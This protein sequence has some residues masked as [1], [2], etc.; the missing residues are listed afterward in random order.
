MSH[1]EPGR[2]RDVGRQRTVG[3]VVLV[4]LVEKQLGALRRLDERS[5]GVQVALTREDRV[6]VHAV[7]LHRYLVW[8]TGS[9]L[10]EW[11][12]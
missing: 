11:D 6:G 12:A 4:A 8:P 7:H 1:Q 5:G 3:E 9:E 2:L 10:V